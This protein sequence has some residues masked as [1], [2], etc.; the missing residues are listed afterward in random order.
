M[1][2]SLSQKISLSKKKK[3]LTEDDCYGFFWCVYLSTSWLSKLLDPLV[4]LIW[5]MKIHC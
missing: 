4:H 5:A 3:S 2:L 1:S